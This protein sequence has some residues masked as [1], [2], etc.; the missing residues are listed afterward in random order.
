[1]GIS[2]WRDVIVLLSVFSGLA[3][4]IAVSNRSFGQLETSIVFLDRNQKIVIEKL[5]EQGKINAKT[6]ATLD[7]IETRQTAA[8]Q[9]LLEYQASTDIEIMKLLKKNNLFPERWNTPKK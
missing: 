9:R 7:K 8:E 3:V 1:M 6:V 5:E 2:K 4:T